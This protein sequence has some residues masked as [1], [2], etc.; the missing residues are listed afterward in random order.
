MILQLAPHQM[1]AA[2]HPPGVLP[3]P[4]LQPKVSFGSALQD[5][6]IP[7]PIL[8]PHHETGLIVISFPPDEACRQYGSLVRVL[9]WHT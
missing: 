4:V 9:K 8:G 2:R 7:L 6:H 1:P 5:H 3:S